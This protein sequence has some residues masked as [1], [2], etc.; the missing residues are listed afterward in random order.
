MKIRTKTLGV[1]ILL[2][3]VIPTTFPVERSYSVT[4]V[5]RIYLYAFGVNSGRTGGY[6]YFRSAYADAD[7]IGTIVQ[8][9]ESSFSRSEGNWAISPE[10]PKD[11]YASLPSHPTTF[12]VA[13][14]LKSASIVDSFTLRSY[15]INSTGP[16]D[17]VISMPTQSLPGGQYDLTLQLLVNG[18]VSVDQLKASVLIG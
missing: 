5:A 9:I 3:I 11:P 4:V 16:F 7:G 2:L 15:P 17:A 18:T 14:V 6:G 12:T 1:L 13:A 10:Y 8:L